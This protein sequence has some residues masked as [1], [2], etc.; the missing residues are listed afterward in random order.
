MANPMKLGAKAPRRDDRDYPMR[1]ILPPRGT[2]LRQYYS[3]PF[4]LDQNGYGTCVTNMWT[5][6]LAQGPITHP[7]R[8]RLDPAN[9]PSPGVSWW[10][11]KD[12]KFVPKPGTAEEYAVDMYDK[13]HELYEDPD[14]E[15]NDGA[16]TVD[17]AK[18]LVK[19][20]LVSAYYN[21]SSVDDVVSA[22]LNVG[23]VAFDSA[24]YGSMYSPYKMYDN[25]YIRV[26]QSSGIRGY[27]AYLLDGVELAPPS[28][29]PFIRMHN[30]WDGAWGHRGTARIP[31]EPDFYILFG[32]SAYVCREVVTS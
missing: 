19:R 14:P 29:P 2:K 5:H 32:N 30:S 24:W 21:A 4:T 13:V 15:R 27:H 17:G 8:A 20:G 23:P 3:K 11:Q 12:G 25:S 18:L 26:D 16:Y 10:T 28:G 6:Y 31:I 22:L 7:D 9:Q 1:A